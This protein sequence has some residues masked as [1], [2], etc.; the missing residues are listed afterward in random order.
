MN[1]EKQLIRWERHYSDGSAEY[2]DETSAKNFAE[3]LSCADGLIVSR[4]Y[5]QMKP[6][7]WH[8]LEQKLNKP[9]VMESVLPLTEDE[10]KTELF[11]IVKRYQ[12]HT[13]GNEAIHCAME[14][15]YVFN[16]VKKG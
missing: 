7:K 3:N 5:I 15:M 12:S 13:S 11:N 2:T 10:I 9:S 8:A 14:I 6:V 4:N 16:L 1:S